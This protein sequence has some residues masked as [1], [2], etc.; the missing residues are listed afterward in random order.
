MGGSQNLGGKKQ[1]KGGKVRDSQEGYQFGRPQEVKLALRYDPKG[2]YVC[3]VPVSSF[4][5]K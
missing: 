2:T 3:T 4:V 5:S 1:R